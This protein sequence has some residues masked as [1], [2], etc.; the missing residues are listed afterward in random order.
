MN[1]KD[2]KE[3]LKDIPD[4]I[5]VKILEEGGYLINVADA[6]LNEDIDER[7]FVISH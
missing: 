3:K 7:I 5:E 4:D 1:A 2:L 6:W